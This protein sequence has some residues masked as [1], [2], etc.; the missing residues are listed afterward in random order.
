MHI[1]PDVALLTK[2]AEVIYEMLV[3]DTPDHED[4]GDLLT[5]LCEAVP[6]VDTLV[7]NTSEVSE[8]VDFREALRSA[9]N[10]IRKS[11]LK[12]TIRTDIVQR[13]QAVHVTGRAEQVSLVTAGDRCAD[14]DGGRCHAVVEDATAGDEE[15]RRGRRARWANDVVVW[16]EGGAMRG[17][18][19]G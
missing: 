1:V 14:A 10:R 17:S 8:L 7:Q 3:S 15:S 11:I 6:D 4:V 19:S 2:G 5:F 9:A 18:H 12:T 16:P 13:Y